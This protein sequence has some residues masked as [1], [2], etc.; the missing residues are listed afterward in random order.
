MP[1]V[2][3]G[4]PSVLESVNLHRLTGWTRATE[5]I[6][7][8]N[9]YTAEQMECCGFLNTAVDD[10]VVDEVAVGL[11][12]DTMESDQAVIAQQKRLFHT[13]KNSFETEAIADSRR[14]F[15]LAFV[16]KND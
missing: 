1:E 11:L 10:A 16:R 6:V 8:G 15:A 14:E 12:R 13:S 2:R 3:I 7:T 5:M 9:R 4:I